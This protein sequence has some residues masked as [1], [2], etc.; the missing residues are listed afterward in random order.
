MADPPRRR[1]TEPITITSSSRLWMSRSFRMRQPCRLPTSGKRPKSTCLVK[2]NSLGRMVAETENFETIRGVRRYLVR[3]SN[4]E[5]EKIFEK[6]NARKPRHST[7][8]GGG[9]FNLA[10]EIG[11]GELETRPLF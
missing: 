9:V 1:A 6:V 8:V 5:K 10:E 3:A 7:S 11:Y 2:P 4:F